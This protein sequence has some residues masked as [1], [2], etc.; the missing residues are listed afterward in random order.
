MLLYPDNESVDSWTEEGSGDKTRR[1]ADFADFC[2]HTGPLQDLKPN[3]QAIH[4]ILAN[5][6]GSNTSVPS[7]L[8]HP[9]MPFSPPSPAV[10]LN[11]FWLLSLVIDPP[12]ALLATLFQTMGPP[13]HEG[14][15]VSHDTIPH[16][17]GGSRKVSARPLLRALTRLIIR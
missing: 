6:T 10:W 5:S 13:V 17:Q 1:C 16:Q 12:C 8:P 15:P 11:S 9:T 7:M 2:V 14:Y 4:Q 3:S